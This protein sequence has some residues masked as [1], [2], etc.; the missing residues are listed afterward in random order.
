MV[1]D[2]S[3]IGIVDCGGI[4][5]DLKFDTDLSGLTGPAA[6]ALVAGGTS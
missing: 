3:S 6:G 5:I 4:I 1:F 2:L